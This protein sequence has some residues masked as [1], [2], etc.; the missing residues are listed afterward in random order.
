[1]RAHDDCC[2]RSQDWDVQIKTKDNSPLTKADLA[3]NKVTCDA[4]TEC[5]PDIPM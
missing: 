2:C 5:Y 1:M 3:A 4:L